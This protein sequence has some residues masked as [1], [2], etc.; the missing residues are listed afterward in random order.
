MKDP[1][2]AWLR[3][4]LRV[5]MLAFWMTT[6]GIALIP[7]PKPADADVYLDCGLTYVDACVE[8]DV[9]RIHVKQCVRLWSGTVSKPTASATQ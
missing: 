1:F 6:V 3:R 8:F 5:G 2:N 9:G 7:T 4:G